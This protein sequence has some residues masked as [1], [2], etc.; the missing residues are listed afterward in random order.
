VLQVQFEPPSEG[1]KPAATAGAGSGLKVK[2]MTATG[3]HVYVSVV[4][5]Q[6]LA[7]GTELR[8]VVDAANRRTVTTLSGPEVTA[9]REKNNL[10]AGQPGLPGEIVIVSTDPPPGD[11]KAVKTTALRVNGPGDIDIFD[12]A[13]KAKSVKAVWGRSLTQE[14]VRVGEQDQDLLTFDGNAEFIDLKADMRLS[15]TRLMLW[16]GSKAGAKPTAS[17]S[18]NFSQAVPQRLDAIGSVASTSPDL[19]IKDTDLMKLWFRDIPTPAAVTANAA[20]PKPA[21]PPVAAAPANPGAPPAAA[22]EPPKP[23]PPIVLTARTIESWLVRYPQPADAVATKSAV[24]PPPVVGGSAG[25]K[26]EL[27]RAYCE[28]RVVVHQDPTEPKKVQRG[29]DIAGVKLN[30]IATRVNDELGQVMTVTGTPGAFAEVHFETTSLFGPVIKIDQLSNTVAIDGVGSLLMPSDTDF[31][32]APTGGLNEL[33]IRFVKSMFFNGAKG[34]AEFLGQVNAVQRPARDALKPPK[35]VAPVVPVAAKIA[36]DET[37]SSSRLLCH[38]LDVT[39]DRPIYFNQF[40]RDDTDKPREPGD[41]PK[42][43]RADCVPVPDD[44][45]PPNAGPLAK[46]VSYSEEVYTRRNALVKAQ[47][48]EGRQI[49]VRLREKTQELFA[50]GPGEVRILQRDESEPFRGP[51]DNAGPP[52]PRKPG[53]EVPFKLTL[54]KYLDSMTAVDKNKLFQTANFR[55]GANVWQIPTNNINLAFAAH[56][57]PAGTTAIS[58]STSMEV[59]TSRPRP[60]APAEQEMVAV[61]NAEFSNDDYTGHGSRITFKAKDITLEGT[62]ERMA[63]IYPRKRSVNQQTGTRAVT[64]IYR[65]DGTIVGDRAGTGIYV[66]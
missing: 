26:Y 12:A 24:P 10:R 6:L 22:S 51:G 49:E 16:L 38:R 18:G 44:E 14:R 45:L 25:L 13:T 42:M 1:K 66:P 55:N 64:I 60:D 9:N 50:T 40:K 34:T 61:G 59:S 46:K 29:L 37:W 19:V 20:K 28:D 21:T 15:A 36:A 2:A 23:K 17:G 53:E 65:K 7:Q 54:V 33:E 62:T 41:G 56:L 4:S 57:A 11:A 31:S 52:P 32:G 8:Y 30:L 39:F 48:I 35:P 63:S 58:C 27:E 3:Q 43:R 47:L 5:E